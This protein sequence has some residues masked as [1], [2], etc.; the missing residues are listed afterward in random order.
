M[1]RP[2]FALTPLKKEATSRECRSARL[3]HRIGTLAPGKA[4]DIGILRRQ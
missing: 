3:G 4:A 2:I 1:N